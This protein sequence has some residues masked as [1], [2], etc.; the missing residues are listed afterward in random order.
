M[1]IVNPKDY[2][3]NVNG[4]SAEQRKKNLPYKAAGFWKRAL[5]YS[6]DAHFYVIISMVCFYFVLSGDGTAEE[7]YAGYINVV[8]YGVLLWVIYFVIA[9]CTTGG[10]FG[11]HCAGL[12]VETKDG[13]K[14]TFLHALGRYLSAFLNYLTL[15]VGYLMIGFT[16]KK[17]GL[18]DIV[19]GTRVVNYKQSRAVKWWLISLVVMIAS[20]AI[21][22][23][24]FQEELVQT[25][26][27]QTNTYGY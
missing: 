27:N 25:F 26:E 11:K 18:H 19:S 15:L 21:I 22:T 8:N 14:L 12:R 24:N 5:A 1:N 2:G 10:T 3:V 23:L 20:M 17:I 16:R 9:E 7:K 6:I 13:E 4:T